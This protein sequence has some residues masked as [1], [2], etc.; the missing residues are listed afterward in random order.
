MKGSVCVSSYLSDI[1]I[2][3]QVTLEPI[4]QIANRAGIDLG[5]LALY[6]K[7]KAKVDLKQLV[8]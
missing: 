2:A 6:G 7:Y 3:K 5:S 1:E 4:E 8:S